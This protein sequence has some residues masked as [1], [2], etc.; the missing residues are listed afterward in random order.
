M[1]MHMQ[2]EGAARE[3]GKGAS[4]WDTFTHKHPGD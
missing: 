1:H 2:F 4:V 3:G